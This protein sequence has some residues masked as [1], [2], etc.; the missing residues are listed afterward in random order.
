MLLNRYQHQWVDLGQV[1]VKVQESQG[2]ND[3]GPGQTLNF[4]ETNQTLIWV[5]LNEVKI[6][7]WL[8]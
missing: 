5:D 3:L 1:L 2:E 6:A 7:C 8:N 4:H